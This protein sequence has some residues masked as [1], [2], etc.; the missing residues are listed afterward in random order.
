MTIKAIVFTFHFLFFCNSLRADAAPNALELFSSLSKIVVL[1]T[2]SELT[3]VG[4]IIKLEH[5]NEVRY[6]TKVR[7]K[8]LSVLLNELNSDVAL[9]S[10]P[11]LNRIKS[12]H[13]IEVICPAI[14][15]KNGQ[16]LPIFDSGKPSEISNLLIANVLIFATEGSPRLVIVD[17][18]NTDQI[19][20]FVRKLE[21]K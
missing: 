12:G 13:E 17:Q 7:L 5:G 11:T 20:K 21:T 18:V 9:K 8:I 14:L 19:E 2:E 1:Q 15:L 16:A 3:V 6:F 4:P 10:D